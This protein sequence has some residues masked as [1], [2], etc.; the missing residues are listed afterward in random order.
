LNQGLKSLLFANHELEI[1][2]DCLIV[3]E[4]FG[5]NTDYLL[6]SLNHYCFFNQIRR[7][8]SNFEQ[9]SV[10]TVEKFKAPQVIGTMAV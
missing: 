4:Q 7:G 9:Q 8:I 3:A 5:F 10:V 1:C 2:V 6:V